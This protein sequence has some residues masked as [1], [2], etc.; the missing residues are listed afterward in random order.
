MKARLLALV[1]RTPGLGYLFAWLLVVRTLRAVGMTFAGAVTIANRNSE[2]N[3]L[4]RA[5]SFTGAATLFLSVHTGATGDNGANELA[6]TTR[7]SITFAAAASAAAASS[8][9]QTFASMPAATTTD[10]GLWSASTG[11]TFQGGGAL[12]AS[13][14][15]ASGDTLAFATGAVTVTFA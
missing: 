8:N 10:L 13:K 12:T 6:G 14:T 5:T 1:A 3:A 15:T 4:L 11:G 2:L 7:Q 9:G